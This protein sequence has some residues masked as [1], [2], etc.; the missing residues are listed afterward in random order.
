MFICSE[1]SD[2]RTRYLCRRCATLSREDVNGHPAAELRRTADRSKESGDEEKRNE[3]LD[4][5]GWITSAPNA[6]Q[7][8]ARGIALRLVTAPRRPRGSDDLQS[9]GVAGG[10]ETLC[11]SYR[12]LQLLYRTSPSIAVVSAGPRRVKRTLVSL[13]TISR[14]SYLLS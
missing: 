10:N 13:E 7:V 8:C 2:F 3:I 9:Y 6:L 1:H 14:R 12:E 4:F 5:I 11:C